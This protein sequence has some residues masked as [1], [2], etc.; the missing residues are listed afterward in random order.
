MIATLPKNETGGR[1][2]APV[3]AVGSVEAPGARPGAEQVVE[4]RVTGARA[5]RRVTIAVHTEA[6][7]RTIYAESVR[8]TRF[9]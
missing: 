3:A 9:K 8:R 5:G 2:V 6:L 1:A 7:A 4:A